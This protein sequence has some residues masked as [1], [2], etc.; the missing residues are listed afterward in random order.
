LPFMRPRC[1]FR[2]FTFFGINIR[3]SSQLAAKSQTSTTQLNLSR[4]RQA[5]GSCS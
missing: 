3:N 1:C 4:Q 5:A 2:Y